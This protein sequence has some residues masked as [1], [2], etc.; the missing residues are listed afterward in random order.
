MVKTILTLSGEDLNGEE[1]LPE[2]T[3]FQNEQRKMETL[4][5]PVKLFV[6]YFLNG[7]TKR[8]HLYALCA[9]GF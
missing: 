6:I 5:F 3:D 7:G 8:Q 4:N 2:Q 1:H 9:L